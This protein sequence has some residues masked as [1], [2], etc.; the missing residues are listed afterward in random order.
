[1][2]A[3]GGSCERQVNLDGLRDRLH[4]AARR[5]TVALAERPSSREAGSVQSATRPGRSTN[6]KARAGD[7]VAA[8]SRR[9]VHPFG[10][11]APDLTRRVRPEDPSQHT[12]S[13]RRKRARCVAPVINRA[14]QTGDT[15]PFGTNSVWADAF[16]PVS[17]PAHFRPAKNGELRWRRARSQ[18]LD[19]IERAAQQRLRGFAGSKGGVSAQRDSLV[20]GQRM[21]ALQRLECEDIEAGAPD[22]P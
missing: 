8:G 22:C 12:F 19:D 2:V 11:L 14:A 16:S 13:G 10:D 3:A 20:K 1:M 18:S 17:A 5:I 21:V 7:R 9:K 15:N 4:F 6:K